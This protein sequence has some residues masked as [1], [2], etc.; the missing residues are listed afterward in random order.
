M[1][2]CVAVAVPER[3]ADEVR[4]VFGRGYVVSEAVAPVLPPGLVARRVAA[5]GCGCALVQELGDGL[6]PEGVGVLGRLAERAGT[7]DRCEAVALAEQ[8]AALVERR[9][10]VAQR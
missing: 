10:L 8:A 6:T 5:E 9:W 1:C 4:A 2:W 3:H 7:V